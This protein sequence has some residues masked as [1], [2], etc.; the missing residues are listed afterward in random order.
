MVLKGEKPVITKN[1]VTL[2]SSGIVE[3]MV[4]KTPEGFGT[5]GFSSAR[6]RNLKMLS[7]N[8]ISPTKENI[9]KNKYPFKRPLFILIHKNHKPE[10]KRFV[11]FILSK[12]GQ[13]IISSLGTISLLDIK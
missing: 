7:L 8:G 12:E 11:D 2:P 9:V 3:Q 4:E 1:T 13:Q 5:T 10:I 6:K